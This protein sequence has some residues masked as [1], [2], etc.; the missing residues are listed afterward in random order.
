MGRKKLLIKP[1]LKERLTLTKKLQDKVIQS[2]LSFLFDLTKPVY[3]SST[4]VTDDD[5]LALILSNSDQFIL[6]NKIENVVNTLNL[7]ENDLQVTFDRNKELDPYQIDSDIYMFET[8]GSISAN[9]YNWFKK[10]YPDCA[11]YRVTNWFGKEV[12]TLV[13][14]LAEELG[15]PVGIL[16]TIE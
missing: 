2:P 16:K 10:T 12:N 5:C 3:T 9:Q 13:I 4:I 14:V 15:K 1:N 6:D 7:D 11:F 8:I